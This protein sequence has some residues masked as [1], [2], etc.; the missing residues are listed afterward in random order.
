MHPN[1][2]R[3]RLNVRG[4]AEYT[5]LSKA[6]LDKARVS[7]NGPPYYMIGRRV[8]YAF[9]DLDAWIAQHRRTSTSDRGPAK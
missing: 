4:A 2:Y 7:G 9:D 6:Y 1:E 5:G 3:K 8:V